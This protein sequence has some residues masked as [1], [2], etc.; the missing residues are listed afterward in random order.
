MKTIHLT[1]ITLLLLI[2]SCTSKTPKKEQLADSSETVSVVDSVKDKAP[3]ASLL[4]SEILEKQSFK[5][6]NNK[7]VKLTSKGG[8][9]ITI[10]KNTF[11]DS[12]GNA[13]EGDIEIEYKEAL[14]PTD[15]VLG[16]MTT[17][18]N[19]KFLESGGMV[20]INATANGEQ[21]AIANNKSIDFDV[22]AKARKK[23]MMLFEGK[24]ENGKINWVE[25]KEIE[26]PKRIAKIQKEALK[27]VEPIDSFWNS[28][29]YQTIPNTK[30]TVAYKVNNSIYSSQN[31]SA[32]KWEKINS[33]IHRIANKNNNIPD[34]IYQ[35]EGIKVQLKIFPSKEEFEKLSL[36]R[37]LISPLPVKGTNTFAEDQT[38]SYAFK[39]KK[40][41]WANIDR[42]FSDPRTKDVEFITKIDKPDDFDNVYISILFPKQ[43]MYIPGYQKKDGTFSFTHGDYEEPKFP[44]GETAIV[45]ATAYKNNVPHYAL[46]N[47]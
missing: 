22:P 14:N 18:Y 2:F 27:E 8:V 45:L 19:G 6:N 25:P 21:L 46:K 10:N 35:I 24:E 41:G 16:N 13:V 15:I 47:L 39:V 7:T 3:K 5:V 36:F 38:A 33:S 23:G 32:T 11:V 9:K 30:T 29:Y 37:P 43:N 28:Y 4:S 26:E 31:F 1:I 44:I 42:L 34:T 40:L 17:T 12:E 20:Y